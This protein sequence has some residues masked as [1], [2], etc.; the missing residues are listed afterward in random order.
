MPINEKFIT[1]K[2]LNNTLKREVWPEIHVKSM[3]KM[4]KVRTVYDIGDTKLIMVS[5]DN[6]ST[7]D[8]VHKRQVFAKGENLDAISSF[9]FEK[10]EN[11]IKNHFFAD[12]APNTWLVER[13]DPIR[14][15]FVF[16]QYLTG[17]GWKAY[18]ESNGPEKGMNFCGVF[19]R[20][21]YRKN[22]KL[23]ELIFTPTAKGQ[24][25]DFIIPEFMAVN[26][27]EDD[28]KL[29]VA[30]IINNYQA[31]G[32]KDK[33]DLYKI[34]E[35]SKE[36][37]SF[38]HTDLMNKGY[39]LADTKWEFGYDKD[40]KILLIDE[41]VTPDS[42][43]F[44]NA[45]EYKLNP[46]KNEFSIVQDDKQHFR[47]HIESIGLHLPEKKAELAEYWMPDDVLKEGVIKYCNIREAITGTLPVITATPRIDMISNDLMMLG[48]LE[49]KIQGSTMEK[50]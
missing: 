25:R 22:E 5:S 50:K 8:V 24:A 11:I 12:L 29:D 35:A 43:R 10:T 17:S 45:K 41:C 28:P 31:F 15:E 18:K 21:G 19:L 16:R 26:S 38:I 37:Y 27:D 2:V 44:W 14:I 34:I 48:L 20:P 39:L 7:H 23:D 3:P 1:P 13:T 40:K 32:L 33:N 42:S 36:L 6:L 46:E 30:A 49:D 9:Y 47:D 4:G